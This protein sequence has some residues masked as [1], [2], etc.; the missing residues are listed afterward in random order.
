M[1]IKLGLAA[2]SGFQDV[3][4]EIEHFE[5]H[6]HNKE[7]WYGV[8]AGNNEVNAIQD[9]LTPFRT[10]SGNGVYGAGVCVMGTSD[11]LVPGMVKFD[12]H[13]I[14]IK[15]TQK[16]ELNKY[17]LAWGTGTEAEAITAGNYST[18]MLNPV[19]ATGRTVSDQIMCPK[20]ANGTKVWISVRT[21]TSTQWVD[22][23]I[24]GHG[25]PV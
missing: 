15:D 10:T 16:A 5:A 20:L 12:L 9:N 25:Y 4:D 1:V 23:F 14:L 3:I 19:V 2:N 24:G 13:K 11:V 21:V 17:R 6:F 8:I 22:F 7:R 18:F